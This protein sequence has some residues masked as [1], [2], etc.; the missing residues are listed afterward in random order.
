MSGGPSGWRGGAG[1]TGKGRPVSR[2]GPASGWCPPGT[3]ALC[4]GTASTPVSPAMPHPGQGSGSI[5]EPG[6][7]GPGSSWHQVT[8]PLPL[9]Q[10]RALSR[11][12]T[13]ATLLPGISQGL[14]LHGE[15]SEEDQGWLGVAGRNSAQ[16]QPLPQGWP[17]T[18]L[19]DSLLLPAP[20]RGNATPTVSRNN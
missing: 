15:H 8:C 9:E 17:P 4:A 12:K 7:P 14:G 11:R 19:S 3:K 1:R 20:P 16:S 5:E 6:G 10:Y 13:G 18:H 2:E